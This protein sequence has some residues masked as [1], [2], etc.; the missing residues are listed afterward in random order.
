MRPL[1]TI[2]PL[3][4]LVMAP[5]ATAVNRYNWTISSSPVHP[6]ANNALPTFGIFNLYLWLHCAE[7][8]GVAAAEFDIQG[9]VSAVLAFTAMNGFLNAGGATN[10]LLATPCNAGP[11]VAGSWLCLSL[12]G[13]FCLVPSVNGKNVGVDCVVFAEHV[14]SVNGFVNGEAWPSCYDPCLLDYVEPAS[15]GRVKSLFRN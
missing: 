4:V 7:P 3:V 14:N 12:P 6:L 9:P 10:L 2:V 8:G 15:W 13:E 11:V 5:A 1:L